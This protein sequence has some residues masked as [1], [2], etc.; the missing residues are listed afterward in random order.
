MQ[1]DCVEIIRELSNYV[2]DEL[3]MEMRAAIEAHL[4]SCYRCIAIYD[5]VRNVL[6]L[7]NSWGRS[8]EL[9]TG[10]SARLYKKLQDTR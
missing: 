10:F 4:A 6:L 5:G 3:S 1:L 7:V 9:P 2:D 8:I